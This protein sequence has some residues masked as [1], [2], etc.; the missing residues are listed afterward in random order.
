MITWKFEE[1][2]VYFQSKAENLQRDISKMAYANGVKQTAKITIIDGPANQFIST[3][4]TSSDGDA[5]TNTQSTVPV[6][7]KKTRTRKQ[8][9]DGL[10]DLHG[11]VEP[12]ATTDPILED[13]VDLEFLGGSSDSV[14]L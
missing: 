12:I 10:S 2:D 1:L 6:G 13:N 4:S 3:D 8:E 9:T 11:N 14:A 5:S 7:T